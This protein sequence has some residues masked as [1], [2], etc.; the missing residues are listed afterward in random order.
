MLTKILAALALLILA[1]RIATAAVDINTASAEDLDKLKGIGPVK[2]KAIVDYRIKN[3]PF[4]SA[5]DIK[6]VPGIGDAT[7]N[8]IKGEITVGAGSGLRAGKAADKGGTSRGEP[9]TAAAAAPA[10]KSDDKGAPKS[11]TG[12]SESKK[13]EGK[14]TEGEG[15]KTEG[16]GK[17][18]AKDRPKSDDKG[19]KSEKADRP[20]Q[21]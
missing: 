17:A 6:K 20:A 19:E 21:K 12:K 2:A 16:K 1:M 11:D 4:K 9:R 3:G 14:K 15:K 10:G 5:E 8:E 7:F 18:D 13:A